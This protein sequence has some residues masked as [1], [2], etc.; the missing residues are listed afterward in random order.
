MSN[1]NSIIIRLVIWG[2][3]A[4][5][6]LSA[7][8]MLLTRTVSGKNAWNTTLWG[9]LRTVQEESFS[10]DAID[11]LEFDFSS[12]DISV[13]LTQED[14]LQVKLLANRELRPE[15]R[16]VSSLDNGRVVVKS[17]PQVDFFSLWT[18][19][20]FKR[21]EVYLPEQYQD[22]IQVSTAS[23]N[24]TLPETLNL[25]TVT[26]HLSSGD[27][28]GGSVSAGQLDLG[29]TSGN[30]TLSSVNS[31]RYSFIISSGDTTIEALEGTGSIG[32]S[33][34]NIR[35]GSVKGGAQE[36]GSTSGNI[37][38]GQFQANGQISTQSG[39]IKME[40]VL[41]GGDVNVRV[42]SGRVSIDLAK[43]AA[44]NLQADVTSG[45]VRSTLP[46]SFDQDGKHA[47]GQ[48]GANPG[49]T[50]SIRTTSGDILLSQAE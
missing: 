44:V 20:G 13:I 15:E 19:N 18:L 40:N 47:N 31:G 2:A 30:I 9:D 42:T 17:Q 32:S 37:T 1:R 10:L 24:I 25:N 48:I 38:L 29:V 8:L 14:E 36:I 43:E 28:R 45:D 41:P 6:L 35:I 11:E 50:L 7:L 27:L 4:L 26:L 5:F 21:L 49:A 22:A 3:I 39:D 33:S 34:G 16:F 12:M 46:L 23:G